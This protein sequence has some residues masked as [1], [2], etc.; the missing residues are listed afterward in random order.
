MKAV[1]ACTMDC[2]DAC[3]LVVHR[4]PDGTVA[5]EGNPDN[6]FTSG[7]TCHKIKQHAARLQNRRRILQPLKRKGSGWQTI[8]WEAALDLC[9]AHI[10]ELRG[11]PAAILHIHS[12]GAKGVLKEATR[13]FF[14][15]LGASRIR[16]SLCDA[17]GYMA[18]V[19]DFGSRKNHDMR[20]LCHASY[21]VNWGKDLSRSSIHTAAAV[22][23]ARQ[24][25][26]EVLT[27][28]P[29]GDGNQS[30]S[31]GQIRIRPGTDRFLAAAVIRLFIERERIAPVVLKRTQNGNRFLA[32]IAAHP[33][34][35]LAA[36]CDV[37]AEDIERLF[38][39]YAAAKPVATL[40]GAG[41]Q[42]YRH[43]GENIRFINALALLSG[44]IGRPGGGSYFHLHSYRNLNLAW[45][46]AA[47][48]KPRRSFRF[49]VIGQEIL[50]ARNPPVKMIWVNGTNVVNQ[51]PD[52]QQTVRAFN[53]VGFKVVADAFMND[54]A[55]RADL[56]LP[57]TL[58]LEQEDIIGSFLHEYVQYVCPVL[59]APAEARDD[60]WMLAEIGKRLDP[61]IW[62]P[63]AEACLRAA[64][65]IPYLETS[66]EQLRH[67]KCQRASRP[68]IAYAG[69]QFDHRDR[70]YRFPSAL[71]AE[72]APP[73][74][75]PLRLLT[76][77]RR[78]AIHSQML[79][80]KQRRPPAVWVA[81]DCP[82]LQHLDLNRDVIL[83]SPLAHL[84]VSLQTLPGLHPDVVLYRRGDWMNQG[85]G[86]NQ[87]IAAGLTDIGSG[88]A[89][90][91]QY[92]RLEN[93]Q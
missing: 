74:A 46:E 9:A 81:P 63:D 6:P 71:H 10:Q 54:T 7:F 60:L 20:D 33:F 92:V 78:D 88:A 34:E 2:P 52:S 41:L 68:A 49:P 14:A 43:G 32:L 58:M 57:C 23:Q 76:L 70:R 21:I 83:V 75:Y 69:L 12:D 91:D 22:Q 65:D 27:I 39:V 28:S 87:L 18:Y 73:P 48:K 89:F 45:T 82:G 72:P 36:A 84:K 8:S 31:D 42:R 61:P 50:A 26:C 66:L 29:G 40:V 53:Q 67:Q 13:L 35:H 47:A 3:S 51:A 11:E 85:G 64:L 62:L 5:I 79:A 16:G 25:G 30:F 44:N 15:R 38:A 80:E 86:A 24:T 77:V 37:P 59:P 1:T 56:V 19:H 90:Y 17:A 93:I 55:Q 4:K